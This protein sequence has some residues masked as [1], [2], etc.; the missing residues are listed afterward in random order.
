MA[1]A[2]DFD[3][4][5]EPYHLALGEIIKGNPGGYKKLYS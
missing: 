3:E 4:V 1:T 5:V 2:H